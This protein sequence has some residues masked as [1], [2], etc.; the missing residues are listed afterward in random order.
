MSKGGY[1]TTIEEWAEWVRR[2]QD[3]IYIRVERVRDDDT[4]FMVSVPLSQAKGA[5]V[6]EHMCN[7]IVRGHVPHRIRVEEE[8]AP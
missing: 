6:V 3:T 1:P 8:E 2:Y 7:W 5:E 4:R